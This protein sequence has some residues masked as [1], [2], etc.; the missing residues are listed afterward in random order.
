MK[1]QYLNTALAPGNGYV[2]FSCRLRLPT[3]SVQIRR[4]QHADTLSPNAK[5]DLVPV[6]FSKT[7]SQTRTKEKI[8]SSSLNQRDKSKVDPT[9]TTSGPKF[10]SPQKPSAEAKN[11]QLLLHEK[12]LAQRRKDAI[13]L[14]S[15][16]VG[17]GGIETTLPKKA[18]KKFKRIVS[19]DPQ[20]ASKRELKSKLKAQRSIGKQPPGS[21]ESQ[22]PSTVVSSRSGSSFK[23]PDP[24]NLAGKRIRQHKKKES[25]EAT[26]SHKSKDAEDGDTGQDRLAGLETPVRLEL[27][28]NA[29]NAANE[30]LTRELPS[31]NPS[32]AKKKITSKPAKVKEASVSARL[33]SEAGGSN[34]LKVRRLE[35]NGPIMSPFHEKMQAVDRLQASKKLEASDSVRRV[36]ASRTTDD[37]RTKVRTRGR[38]VGA[39]HEIAANIQKVA[40]SELEISALD[41]E[42]PPVPRLSYGLERVLFNPGVYHLQDPRSRVFNFDPYLQTIMP[43]AEFNFDALKEYITS[44]RDTALRDLA[45]SHSKRYVGSSSSMTS[46]LAHFHYLLSQWRSI[47]TK[48]LSREFPEQQRAKFT[49]IQR[50]PSAI[51]LKW[52]NGTYAI[53]ADKEFAGANVLM[54]LGKS[55][56]KLL[57][58]KTED[59]ERYRKSS[60]ERVSEEEQKAPESYHYSTMG[61]FIMRSQLDAHD[62]RLPGTGMFDLKTRAVVSVRMDAT[63]YEEGAGYQIRS[64]QGEWESYEREYFDMIRSAFLKY[65]LQVRMGRMDGIFVAFH[66]T[67]RIFGFQYISLSEMDST[68]HGQWDTTLGDQEFKLSISL[69][70]DILNKAT[71]KYPGTSLRLHFE[72]REA[73]TPFMYIFAEPVT[74][75]QITAIQTANDAIV[76]EFEQRL[77]GNLGAATDGEAVDQGWENLQANVQDAMDE[78]IR[79]PNHNDGRQDL[80]PVMTSAN[81]QV[82][83]KDLSSESGT[84]VAS[85][86]HS[87][88]VA[89]EEDDDEDSDAD[90]DGEG[91]EEE[92]DE[93]EN[94]EADEDDEQDEDESEIDDDNIVPEGILV[95]GAVGQE[96]EGQ[97]SIGKNI[98]AE[99][100]EV[101]ASQGEAEDGVADE[102][103]Q[104][105]AQDAEEGGGEGADSLTGDNSAMKSDDGDPSGT[106]HRS[107]VEAETAQSSHGNA[108]TNSSSE[109]GEPDD[110]DGVHS[111]EPQ[112]GGD[113]STGADVSFM[114]YMSEENLDDARPAG[115]EVLAMTLTVRN[116]VNNEYVLRPEDLGAKDNWAMEY[117]L[118]EVSSPDRA[119]SLYQACQMRRRKKAEESNSRSDDDEEEVDFYVRMLRNLSRKGAEWRKQ[120]DQKDQ[121]SPVKVLGQAIGQEEDGGS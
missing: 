47:N 31:Q 77:N 7:V 115:K 26:S 113:F 87:T 29:N 120:Q 106:T 42:Q 17:S 12:F 69:L 45:E 50:S 57:T 105:K 98:G 73:Q 80:D 60:S 40:A 28:L 76:K 79:D 16:G 20:R 114:E 34:E 64:R 91:G 96:A 117:S 68:I 78:D 118:E 81:T 22:E 58:L 93:D 61:D 10:K 119:W 94:D 21:D 102:E 15:S 110:G 36:V 23:S 39:Q 55:M 103:P 56:E 30:D 104:T 53:D 71:E 109:A 82:E 3:T 9:S 70:N 8:E 100:Y 51:F 59:F 24:R 63:H 52:R 107:P 83:T 65:S 67:D 62:P 44:S 38:S 1:I 54:L 72:T 19:K 92:E 13:A 48:M 75:E 4:Q 121:G 35:S 99:G 112:S 85:E 49:E 95:N 5:A 25:S 2:C 66:N 108:E 116:K 6:K 101:R 33:K 27:G 46:A 18:V 90:E 43:V 32:T 11:L 88:A 89:M 111:Q 14:Q 86:S 84:P 97:M 74:E 37:K 41:L